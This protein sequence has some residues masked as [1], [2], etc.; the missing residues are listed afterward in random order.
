MHLS[1]FNGFHKQHKF[2]RTRYSACAI[3]PISA[4]QI[5]KIP[6]HPGKLQRM[7]DHFEFRR[8]INI[9]LQVRYRYYSCLDTKRYSKE[10]NILMLA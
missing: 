5:Q 3:E 7:T 10:Y 2:S 4:L 9:S 1:R 8:W 6:M